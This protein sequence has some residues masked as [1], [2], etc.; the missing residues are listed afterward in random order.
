MT[1]EPFTED[2]L[3]DELRA[4]FEE[5]PQ[6][7]NEPGTITTRELAEAFELSYN[8]ALK[9][10]KKLVLAG[11]LEADMVGRSNPWGG[12]PVKGFRYIGENHDPH[13]KT[14]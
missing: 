7:D 10:G 12:H 6:G 8:R 11:I 2:D 4:Y 14:R 1:D 9:I 3:L 13:T 5:P